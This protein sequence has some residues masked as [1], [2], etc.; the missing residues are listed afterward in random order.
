MGLRAG[1]LTLRTSL[2]PGDLYIGGQTAHHIFEADLDVVADVLSTLDPRSLPPTAS[3]NIPE[4]E[5][6]AENVFQPT[7]S[8]FVEAGES[9]SSVYTLMAVAII[10]CAFLRIAENSVSFRCLFELFFCL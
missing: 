5:E 9:C 10:S 1:S 6:V 7:E 2:A 3:E 8:R 4:A